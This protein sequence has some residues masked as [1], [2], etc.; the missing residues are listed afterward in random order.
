MMINRKYAQELVVL[1]EYSPVIGVTGPRQ[2]GKT[3]LVKEFAKTIE[4]PC[5]YLDL[6]KPSD[7]QKLEEAELYFSAN[8]DKCII[9]DE[10]QIK[11]DLFSI[12][13]AMVDE[14]RIPLRFIILG[15][16]TPDIIRDSSESLA[17]R[18]GYID[19]KPFSISELNDT[20]LQKHH[21]LGGFPNS[22]LAKSEKQALKWIDD[23][24]KTY[25]ERDLPLLGLPATPQVTRRLWEMLAW[26]SGNLLNAS[27]IGNSMGLSYHTINNYIDFLE[28]TFLVHRLQP[29]SFNRHYSD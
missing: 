9:L 3:T 26:Q 1:S 27:T 17:G 14:N 23:F 24:I 5:V 4:K 15:S 16:A 28:G 29:F 22:I 25:I 20:H 10:I 13:R 8:Q 6:E 12:I 19:L 11:P 18:I 2:V 7:F 21:F